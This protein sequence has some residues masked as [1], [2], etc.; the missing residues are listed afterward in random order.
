MRTVKLRDYA[1]KLGYDEVLTEDRSGKFSRVTIEANSWKE[2]AENVRKI[3]GNTLVFVKPLSSEVLRYSL[4]NPRVNCIVIERKNSHIF[5]KKSSLNLIRQYKKPVEI[6]LKNLEIDV[7][8]KVISWSKW[9]EYP[10]LSSCASKFNE[11]WSPLSKFSLLVS[12]G[13]SESEAL[14]WIY[15]S[16]LRVLSKNDSDTY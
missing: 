11:L 2:V 1:I 13:A 8:Y 12:L 16:P 7:I 5:G 10:F 9:I 4:R 6:Q 15:I 3:S 14:K